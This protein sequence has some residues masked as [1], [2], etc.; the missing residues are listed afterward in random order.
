MTQEKPRWQY[1]FDN[2]RRAFSLLREALE[3]QQERPLSDIEKWLFVEECETP[4]TS[5]ISRTVMLES[6]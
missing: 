6:A 5:P 1:R 2:Y 3:L 4:Y